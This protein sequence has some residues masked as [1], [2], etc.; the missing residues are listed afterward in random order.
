MWEY[1]NIGGLG[2]QQARN[3]FQ[4][5]KT[6]IS[7]NAQKAQTGAN[8]LL[9]VGRLHQEIL[10]LASSTDTYDDPQ[11][12]EQLK[13]KAQELKDLKNEINTYCQSYF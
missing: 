7:V 6:Y 3:E 1:F 5:F 9:R 12:L 11:K 10:M 13:G 2:F 8:K 4:R